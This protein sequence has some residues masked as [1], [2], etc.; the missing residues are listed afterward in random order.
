MRDASLKTSESQGDFKH[1]PIA[2]AAYAFP[3]AAIGV[4]L[5]RC[6]DCEAIVLHEPREELEEGCLLLLVARGGERGN[7]KK[8]QQWNESEANESHSS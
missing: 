6:C 7:G 2:I 1:C 5:P 4:I 8:Q 3:L